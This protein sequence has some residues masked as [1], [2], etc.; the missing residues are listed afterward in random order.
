MYVCMYVC[1]YVHDPPLERI[2]WDAALSKPE[3]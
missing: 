2:N 1:M 3:I